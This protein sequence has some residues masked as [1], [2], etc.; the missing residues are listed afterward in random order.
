[1]RLVTRIMASAALW[2]TGLVGALVAL[3]QM[4]V[5]TVPPA[6][7]VHSIAEAIIVGVFVVTLWLVSW[8]LCMWL[9]ELRLRRKYAACISP[10]ETGRSE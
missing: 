8:V 3:G 5:V 4:S 1:M 9:I 6:F 7:S 10:S 2:A